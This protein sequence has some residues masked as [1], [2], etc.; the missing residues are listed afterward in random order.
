[1]SARSAGQAAQLIRPALLNA[2]TWSMLGAVQEA[3]AG[4]TEE[5]LSQ[6]WRDFG[7]K[8]CGA[9]PPL[10]ATICGSV[11]NDPDLLALAAAAPPSGQQ[12][13]CHAH[14]AWVGSPWNLGASG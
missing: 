8:E 3:A 4:Q 7:E 6:I 10:Y 13:I 2:S 1:M 5:R 12:A 14:G 9:H 11:A